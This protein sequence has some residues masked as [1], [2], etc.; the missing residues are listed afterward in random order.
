MRALAPKCLTWPLLWTLVWLSAERLDKSEDS[1]VPSGLTDKVR[2]VQT[3]FFP[4]NQVAA[5]ARMGEQRS[6]RCRGLIWLNSSESSSSRQKVDV[7]FFTDKDCLLSSSRTT[8]EKRKEEMEGGKEGRKW[9]WENGRLVTFIQH[10]LGICKSLKIH[11]R[12]FC[13]LCDSFSVT[14][15]AYT[16]VNRCL[17]GVL[18]FPHLSGNHY[19]W[20]PS[21]C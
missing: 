7:K 17:G 13:F 11:T 8:E 21:F 5:K 3:D 16:V 18:C 14:P 1:P 12:T 9:R 20:L 6:L 10:F 4:G 15:T 19:S 2:C